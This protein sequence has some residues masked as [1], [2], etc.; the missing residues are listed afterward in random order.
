MSLPQTT[1][2][3]DIMALLRHPQQG[4]PWD[5]EQD[6][7][8]LVPYT[9][10]EAYEVADAVERGDFL[11]LREELGD[12]LL[13]VAFH[14]RI[15]EEQEL[16]CFEDV[17]ESIAAKLE[18]RHPHV[19]GDV[20]AENADAV[21]ANWE[22]LKARERDAKREAGTVPSVLD[23][24]ADCL[25]ALMR[26][27]KL[28]RRAARYGF[29]WPDVKDIF[30]K[31]EEEL[32][33][34]RH[35]CDGPDREHLKEEVGDLLF[36]VANLARYLD[37]DAEAALRGCNRKFTRRFRHIERRLAEQGR[38]LEDSHLA[39]MDAWWNEAK[40]LT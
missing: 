18:R 33:E 10:E 20:E 5:L 16:F 31:I 32:E 4:C 22:A 1:R 28:Q 15:A 11:A 8:S 34:T 26:A 14:S 6:F 30:A 3:L 23:G 12:L 35:A 38:T 24:V 37:I 39:E 25:P 7:A 21:R 36:A 27:D 29:D 13:Q 2:L 40:T 19:F 9:L 17:A